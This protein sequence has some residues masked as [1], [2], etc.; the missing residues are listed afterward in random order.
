MCFP[1]EPEGFPYHVWHR[2]V[3]QRKGVTAEVSASRPER[4]AWVVVRPQD[5]SRYLVWYYEVECDRYGEVLNSMDYDEPG[6]LLNSERIIV[7]A[8]E[9]LPQVLHRW[10]DDLSQFGDSAVSSAPI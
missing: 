4:R 6:M 1:T 9:D 3:R 5:R 10:V 8:V 2:L 7:S